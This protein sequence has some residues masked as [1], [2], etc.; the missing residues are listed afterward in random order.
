MFFLDWFI[1]SDFRVA[2]KTCAT[3]ANTAW[4]PFREGYFGVIFIGEVL[5]FAKRLLLLAPLTLIGMDTTLKEC[6]NSRVCTV[7]LLPCL[8]DSPW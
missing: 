3:M 1:A 7:W 8:L 4:I 5:R 2:V 6:L